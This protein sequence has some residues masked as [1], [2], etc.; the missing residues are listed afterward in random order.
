MSRESVWKLTISNS[1]GNEPPEPRE[2]WPTYENIVTSLQQLCNTARSGDQGYIH[3][4]GHGG[5]AN[6]AFPQLKGENGLDEVLV[7]TN[8]GNS[9]TRYV[10]DVELACLLKQMVENGLVLTV[11]FDS[12]R[13]GG[14]SDGVGYAPPRR[15]LMLESP[16]V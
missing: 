6:M 11:V 14:A 5:R 1:V 13:S 4:F 9:I 8:I 10:R 2:Q 16:T 15:S 7:L 3:Y 12:C